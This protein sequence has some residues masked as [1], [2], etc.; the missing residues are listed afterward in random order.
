[1][2]RGALKFTLFRLTILRLTF[3]VKR[4]VKRRGFKN[5]NRLPTR[6]MQISER[7]S[8]WEPSELFV[9]KERAQTTRNVEQR[10]NLSGLGRV[11]IVQVRVHRREKRRR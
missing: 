1:M 4:N 11:P 9:T 6:Q 10:L 3:D 2:L 5:K 7:Q 8:P